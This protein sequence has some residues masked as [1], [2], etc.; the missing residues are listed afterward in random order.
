MKPILN[1]VEQAKIAGYISGNHH[2]H[3]F[4]FG[5]KILNVYGRIKKFNEKTGQLVVENSSKIKS[6]PKGTEISSIQKDIISI[7]NNPVIQEIV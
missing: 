2:F 3:L 6:Y 7:S 5:D 4:N 1:K